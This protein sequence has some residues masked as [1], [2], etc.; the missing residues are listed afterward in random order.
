MLNSIRACGLAICLLL[1]ACG[2]GEENDASPTRASRTPAQAVASAPSASTLMDWAQRNYPSYFPGTATTQSAPPYTYRYYSQTQNYL[3]VADDTI[4]VMGPASGGH[5]VTVGTLTGYTCTVYPERCATSGL[6]AD[7]SGSYTAY[8]TNG[9]RFTLS[10]DFQSGTFSFS[11]IN[12]AGY[13]SA[14]TFTATATERLYLFNGTAVANQGFRYSRD[15]I[16][17][18]YDF[19]GGARPFVAARSFATSVAEAAGTYSNLGVTLPTVGAADSAIYSSRIAADG[20]LYLCN[21]FT[22]YV[23]GLCPANSVQIY[24]L[25]LSGDTFTATPASANANTSFSFRVA[26]AGGDRLYLMAAINATTGI[27]YFRIG[28]LESAEF[29]SGSAYGGTT[30]GEWGPAAFTSSSYSS[31]GIASDGRTISTSGPLSTMGTS[32]PTG[33]RKLTA[34]NNAFAIQNTQVGVLVGARGGSAAGYMQIG[35]K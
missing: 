16:A 20:K 17:G 27:R 1:A 9:E 29:P 14:G 5:L 13:S 28:V 30:L 32:G 22:V 18:S 12:V 10:L 21:D 8:A 35:G 4:Y 23:I 6:P 11:G 26:T 2:G 7:P 34:V 25:S 24:T 31:S 3:G 19:G 33:M 15:V